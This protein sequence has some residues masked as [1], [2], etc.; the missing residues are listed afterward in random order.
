[1][2]IRDAIDLGEEVIEDVRIEISK[3]NRK[4]KDW[5]FYVW[6]RTGDIEKEC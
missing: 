6:E 1:M 5:Y 3:E 4:A 2:Q